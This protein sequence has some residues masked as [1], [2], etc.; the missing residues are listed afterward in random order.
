MVDVGG[1]GD[2]SVGL[3]LAELLS[4]VCG[5]E[6]ELE[7]DDGAAGRATTLAVAV[8]DVVTDAVCAADAD[9]TMVV[10]RGGSNCC[11]C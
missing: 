9:G 3:E 1:D 7:S 8:L 4:A 5:G 11:G 2:D 6:H 10:G